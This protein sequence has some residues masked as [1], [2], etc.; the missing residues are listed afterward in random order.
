MCDEYEEAYFSL[1]KKKKKKKRKKKFTNGLN[2][3]LPQSV[4]VKKAGVESH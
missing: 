1:K 4:R 3:G 2:L